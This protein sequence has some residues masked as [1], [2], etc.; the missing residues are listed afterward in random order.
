MLPAGIGYL[1][2]FAKSLAQAANMYVLV[3]V[4]GVIGYLID[5]LLLILQDM[6]G[7]RFAAGQS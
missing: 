5:K 1:I 2:M 7:R 3:L 6:I 4:V